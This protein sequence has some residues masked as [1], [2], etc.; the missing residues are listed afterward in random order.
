MK[1]WTCINCGH[2]FRV[3]VAVPP[4]HCKCH[5]IDRD[6]S[7]FI[8]VATGEPIPL[9]VKA[10][11]MATAV[12]RWV[13]AG[14]PSRTDEQ[15]DAILRDHCSQCPHFADSRCTHQ[16]CG[17]QIRSAAGEREK[18]LS[19]ILPGAMLNKLRMGTEKCPA[20]RWS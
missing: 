17:C 6:G 8:D 16:N 18:L 14:R 11:R 5:Y 3:Q 13:D 9:A 4:V 2:S 15:V 10:V 20:G 12:E 1:R 19:W 7:G